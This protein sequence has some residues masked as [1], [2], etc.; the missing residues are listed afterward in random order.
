MHLTCLVAACLLAVGQPYTPAWF[1]ARAAEAETFAKDGNEK[2]MTALIKEMAR[3]AAKLRVEEF[4]D[5]MELFTQWKKGVC[6]FWLGDLTQSVKTLEAIETREKNRFFRHFLYVDLGDAYLDSGR[7]KKAEPCY[8]KGITLVEKSTKKFDAAELLR[9]QLR[10]VRCKVNLGNLGDA[11]ERL[12]TLENAVFEK[13]KEID[14]ATREQAGELQAEW[15]ILQ[16]EID[17]NER[18]LVSALG[19]LET[20]QKKL[21][22]FPKS[23]KAVF[24]RFRCHLGL[25][26]D[27][28]LLARFENAGAHLKHAE[29]LVHSGRLYR[30]ELGHADIKNAIAGLAIEEAYFAVDDDTPAQNVLRNLD[31]AEKNLNDAMAHHDKINRGDDMFTAAVDF[32]RAQVNEL[33]GRVLT[34][35][36]QKDGVAQQQFLDGKKRC[37]AS[38][39]NL[40]DVLQLADNHDRILEVRNR[41]A[42]L[43]LRLGNAKAA[44]DEASAALDLFEK[45]HGAKNL[46]RGR[47]LHVLMEAEH[48]LGNTKDAI[49]YAQEHRRLVDKGLGAIL[50]GLSASEQVQF[51]RRWDT[52]GLHASLRLGIKDGQDNQALADATVE[53]LINGK[54][55]LAEV[56]AAQT[57][58]TRA[59]NPQAFEDYQKAVRRQA[60]ILYGQPTSDQKTV[61]LQYLA[62]ESRK[63]LL[64]AQAAQQVAQEPHWYT[65]AEVRANL[66]ED[67]LYVG[68]Y[69]LR[70]RDYGERVYYAWLVS[71][72]GP[73][74]TVKLGDARTIENLVKIFLR[75]Q[76]RVP[77]IAPGTEKQAELA[78]RKNCLDEL[79]RHV[80]HP[81]QK[82]AAGRKRWIISPDGPLW[83]VPWAALLLPDSR[84]AI[85]EMTFRYAITGRDLVPAPATQ[86]KVGDPLILG[87]PWFNYPDT[88]RQRLRLPGLDPLRLPWD[89]L[90]HSRQECDTVFAIMND[91]KMKPNRL[92]GTMRKEQ[93]VDL[94]RAPRM[95]Y[96]STHAFATLR[97]RVDV[98]DPMLSCALAF[99]GWNYLPQANESNLPGMMTGAEVLGIDLRGT[100]LVVLA[101][102]EAGSD[103][104][105]YGQ[106]PANLRHAFH[107]AGARAVVSALW[108]MNDRSSVELMEPFMDSV[109]RRKLDK[110]SALCE[111]QQ[112][113]IRYLRMYRD[114]AHPY[115][116]AGFT[117]SGS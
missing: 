24:L 85:E 35:T 101:S 112:Q 44:R 16:S 90:D 40:Q 5:E 30:T 96:L 83:N 47:Y 74:Q 89:R 106:S 91:V 77:L 117:I 34:S 50:A 15:Q 95:V 93:L 59:V 73:V 115:Y 65:L 45:K 51:F 21:E 7:S 111:A 18:N 92:Q 8:E 20:T 1:G 103:A 29:A 46:D 108:A 52:P 25:A 56:V 71:R 64:A 114:H 97:G 19:R 17:L 102:C 98:D 113:S 54:A 49:R 69:C 107:L 43:N 76:E 109:Y 66:R 23:K 14:K 110:V 28:W 105:S 36:G 63:R 116:W 99:A 11:K 75:E 38:I 70:P 55:K 22:A 12:A 3:Q 48:Q 84:Y 2:E 80:F 27:Y 100:E 87:D 104:L 39:K 9:I 42:W 41:R 57:Q 58:A 81:I 6:E 78:L 37:D 53:W 72:E 61:Q 88:D 10:H 62:E 79:S 13:T 82:I 32:H 26:R 68:I 4:K 33:R 86:A 67:E 31:Q 94:M 60:Y